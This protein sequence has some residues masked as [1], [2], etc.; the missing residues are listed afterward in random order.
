MKQALVCFL[1]I[2]AQAAEAGECEARLSPPSDPYSYSQNHRK[3]STDFPV[4][5]PDVVGKGY[6]KY[7]Y[8]PQA[9]IEENS[10]WSE[11]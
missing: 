8:A 7:Y 4:V 1:C 5:K 3:L 11:E 9:M 10:S 6:G 2:T